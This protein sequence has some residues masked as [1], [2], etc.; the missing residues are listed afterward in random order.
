MAERQGFEPWI[1]FRVYTLSKRAPSATRPS[2]RWVS[3]QKCPIPRAPRLTPQGNYI[4][5]QFHCSVS[6]EGV[7]MPADSRS[8]PRNPAL[9]VFFQLLRQVVRD[10]HLADGV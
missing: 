6:G 8:D 4:E 1:P 5:A 10:S 9:L 3:L 7:W 2:L